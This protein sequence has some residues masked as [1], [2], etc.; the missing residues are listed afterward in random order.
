MTQ[1]WIIAGLD[2]SGPSSPERTAAILFAGDKKSLKINTFRTTAGDQELLDIFLSQHL[3]SKLIIGIDAP[4]SYQPGGG[5]REGDRQLR[6][7]LTGHGLPSGTVMTP[8]MTRM[9]YLTLRG[10]SVVRLLEKNI[11]GKDSLAI[12]EVHPGGALLLNGA[13]L[14]F[15]LNFKHSLVIRTQLL[16]WLEDRGLKGSGS[17]P[18]DSD[19]L[20]AACG[21]ALAA[22]KWA[23]GNPAWIHPAA[24]PFHPYPIIC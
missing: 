23:A 13:P 11:R 18:P 22:W 19:H 21:A 6:I 10:I 1:S 9:A 17:L 16:A 12:S 2:L 24:P 4:L 20:V 7:F 15:V 5:D 14:D 3:D 8:T